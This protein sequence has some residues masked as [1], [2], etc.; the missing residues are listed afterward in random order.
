VVLYRSHVGRGGA[1]YEPL[2][3]RATV[4]PG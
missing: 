3:T 1:R 2:V 4:A